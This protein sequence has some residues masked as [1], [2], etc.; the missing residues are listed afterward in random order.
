MGAPSSSRSDRSGVGQRH[1]SAQRDLEDRG[2]AAVGRDHVTGV[3]G[4]RGGVPV[5]LLDGVEVAAEDRDGDRRAEQV[6]RREG[7]P[8][9]LR[10]PP[11][12]V[13]PLVDEVHQ[14]ELDDGVQPPGVGHQL[15]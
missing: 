12:R 10:D 9:L 1:P 14:A 4:D 7:Q 11:D 3:P 5:A 6:P 13:Q 15:R 8:T 2:V